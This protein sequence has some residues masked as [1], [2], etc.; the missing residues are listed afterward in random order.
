ML[1]NIIIAIFL[2]TICIA[3]HAAAMMMVLSW[4]NK[5]YKGVDG[6]KTL[7]AKPV[8]PVCM[9]IIIMFLAS[10]FEVV[11]WALTYL[12]T[13]SVQGFEKAL[14]FSMVTFTTLGYGDIVLQGRWRLLAGFEAAIGIILFGWTTAIV[15]AIVQRV[16]FKKID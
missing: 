11:V 3:I 4:L 12:I 2:T 7:Q 10:V 8:F 9:T 13:H 5:R 15:I 6:T 1:L 16:Y 14:Y